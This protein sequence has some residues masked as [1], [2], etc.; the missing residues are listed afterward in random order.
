MVMSI[1]EMGEHRRKSRCGAEDNEFRF[2][3]LHLKVLLD[4]W[5]EVSRKLVALWVWH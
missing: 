1:T 2:R 4:S 5:E 3:M